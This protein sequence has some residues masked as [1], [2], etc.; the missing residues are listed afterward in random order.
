MTQKAKAVDQAANYL[1]QH[2]ST[3]YT[4]YSVLAEELVDLIASTL[5]PEDLGLEKV[6][7]SEDL[8]WPWYREPYDGKVEFRGHG[9][10]R[11]KETYPL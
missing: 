8:A 11:Y 9:P 3:D 4:A 5:S 6:N 7:A 2:V 10:D 1:R